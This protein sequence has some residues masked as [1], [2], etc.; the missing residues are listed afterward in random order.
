MRA[1]VDAFGGDNA[2]NA[3]IEGCIAALKENIAEPV[4]A[5]NRERIVK[6]AADNGLKL[7]GIEIIDAEDDITMHDDPAEILKSKKNCGMA[8][9]LRALRDGGGDAFVSAGSTGALLVGST[10]YV[11]RI[12]GVKRAA[13]GTSLPTASGSYLLLDCG[14]NAECRPEMLAQFGVM[15]SVFVSRMNGI[16]SPT[17]GL[18]N[19]GT[20]DTKGGTMQ[21]EAFELLKKAPVNFI[22]NVEARELPNGAADIIVTDGFTGNIVLKLTEGLARTLLGMVKDVLTDGAKN[23][24]AALV[25]KKD[26]SGLKGKMNYSKIGGAPLLGISKPVIKAHGSSDAVAVKNAIAA[27]V[28]FA[29][30]NAIAEIEAGMAEIKSNGADN[31]VE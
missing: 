1:I 5:G 14:A 22:G 12:K 17:V 9:G 8:V 28:R 6:F 13:I 26:L 27:A 4:L 10:M 31:D 15:A 19:I 30:S 7:D 29:E 16:E 25:L 23:K 21:K 2:P 24:M 3:V 20:E 11:K 18:L